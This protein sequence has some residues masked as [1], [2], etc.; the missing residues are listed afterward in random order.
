MRQLLY[1]PSS[2]GAL[3][4][5]IRGHC[6]HESAG[7]CPSPARGASPVYRAVVSHNTN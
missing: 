5:R 4:S 3:S 7:K 6:P 1:S 2:L